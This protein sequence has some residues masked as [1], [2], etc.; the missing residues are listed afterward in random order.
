MDRSYREAFAEIDEIFKLMPI[1]LLSKIPAQFRQM[2]SENKAMDYKPNIQEPLDEKNLK[3]RETRLI[4]GPRTEKSPF[5][6]RIPRTFPT[7]DSSRNSAQ[8]CA[9]SLPNKV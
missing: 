2:I 9:V 3:M 1:D 5:L 4:F 8:A 6:K 7:K